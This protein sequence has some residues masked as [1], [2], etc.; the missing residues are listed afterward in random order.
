MPTTRRRRQRKA[1]YSPIVQA[2]LDGREI[3]RTPE[4]RAELEQLARCSFTEFPVSALPFL[5][6][7]AS[8]LLDQWARET[9]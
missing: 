1:A 3:E 5:S 4:N 6:G 2:L 8:R 7:W 9:Q